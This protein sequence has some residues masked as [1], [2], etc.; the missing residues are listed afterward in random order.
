LVG[1]PTQTDQGTVYNSAAIIKNQSIVD[2]Y[3]KM[4]LPNYGVFDEHRYFQAGQTAATFNLAE[5]TVGITICEDIWDSAGPIK[6]LASLNVDL[7][8]NLSASPYHR[9]KI[10]Q[11]EEM[12][13]RR[14]REAKSWLV[15]A[16]AVGG[17]DE[18]VFDGSSVVIDPNGE[19][20]A[21]AKSFCEDLLL[22]STA[23][24]VEPTPTQGTTSL[25]TPL[26]E[27]AEIYTALKTGLR[28][29]I[30]KNR[31]EHVV[32]GLSGGIDS[33]LAICIAVD[34][35]GS[36]AVTAVVMPSPYS[37]I[38]TQ[39]DA[40][41]LAKNLECEL[42]EFAIEPL[43]KSYDDV[44]AK[45][46][47]GLAEDV[48]EE[49]IQARIRGNLVMALA[50]KFNWVALATVNKSE[51][52]VGYGTLYGDLVGGFAVLKDCPK[53]LVYALARH[54]NKLNGEIIP[55]TIIDRAPSAELKPNQTDQDLLPPYEI[56]DKIIDHYIEE[57]LSEEELINLGLPPVDVKRV[58]RL[59][60]R[61]EYKRRQVPVGVKITPLAL[62]R[63]RRMPITNRYEG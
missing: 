48:A 34:A 31:F 12:L 13:Q 43:M 19:A 39:A 50:N 14:A 24:A 46:F 62:G 45:Q 51:A 36:E 28:D 63:D 11:R 18:L 56:L 37:S 25:I 38:A 27:E 23:P 2:F 15:F 41:Q 16:N 6:D 58:I 40:R 5:T 26:S 60:D 61:A 10:T 54:Y 21:R 17:Q 9:G 55:H 4:L 57:H 42:V 20:T 52:S 22:V 29:Y 8:V 59:I 3:N 47:E 49:N 35:L 32:L 53:T 33:A 7:I 44:L 1:L 30:K